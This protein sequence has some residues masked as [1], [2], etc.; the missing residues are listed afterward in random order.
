VIPD[1]MVEQVQD[2]ADIVGIVGEYVKLKRVGNSWRGPCPFHQGKGDNFSVLP[3][4]GFRCFVCGE[5][6]SVF[7]FVQ[8]HLG[9]DF[10]ES[11]KLVGA[12]SGITV[13]EVQRRTE[14]PDP[15]TPLWEVVGATAA[16]FERMLWEDDEGGAARTYLAQR[17][18]TREVAER[19]N[20]GYAPRAV[21]ALRRHLEVL[22]FDITRQIEAGVQLVRE[23]GDEPRPR[24]R[25]RLM[26]P[27]HDPRGNAV[28]FGG[29]SIDGSEPKYLNSS[30]SPIFLKGQLLYN[31]HAARHPIRKAERVLVVEG[32]FDVVRTVA[33]GIEE[34]VAPL[35]TALTIEQA[36]LMRRYSSNVFLLY[37]SDQAGLKAT[38]RSGDVLVHEGA[39]VRVVTLPD[40]DDPDT[41]VAKHGAVGLERALHDAVDV[42]DRKLQLLQRGGWFADLHKARRAIDRLI[43]TIRAAAD[44]LTRDL[45]LSRAAQV[46]GVDRDTLARETAM[47]VDPVARLEPSHGDPTSGPPPPGSSRRP[48]VPARR[49][50]AEAERMLVRAMLL[51]R[52][53][54]DDITEALGRIDDEAATGG[55]TLT[56]GAPAPTLRDPTLVAIHHALLDAGTD[57]DVSSIAEGVPPDAVPVLEALVADPEELVDVG[58]TVD[59]SLDRLRIRW[60]Q[61][62]LDALKA[63]LAGLDRAAFAIANE[64][65]LR[66]KKEMVALSHRRRHGATG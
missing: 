16:Y 15:R 6:G 27:I 46:S 42:F 52:G 31:L 9:L 39:S 18:I 62:R 11:V 38:F 8:K 10:V 1:E 2:A 29:R 49:V 17:G 44:P 37:D 25:G 14:G 66:L 22:G 35:G 59:D 61:E 57:A 58:T 48:R 56:P 41:F 4:K 65:M 60:R 23:P 50:G 5:T 53:R 26:F 30:E 20:L 47:A 21:G 43:P 7:S 55:L 36:R 51:Y 33:A 3:G 19:F 32:Y 12:K 40:G 28:G 63:S 24:F 64:E 45:Y 13:E 54:V 34:V